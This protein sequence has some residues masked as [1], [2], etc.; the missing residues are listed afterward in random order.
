MPQQH[1]AWAMLAAPLLTGILS[2][3]P[4]WVH[5]PLSVFWLLGYLRLLRDLA[6][7]EVPPRPRFLPPVRVYGVAAAVLARS[8]GRA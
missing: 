8:W 2:G 7:A 4:A 6:V 3:G 5:P 1:G